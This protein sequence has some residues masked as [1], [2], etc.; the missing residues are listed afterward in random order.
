MVASDCLSLFF[1]FRFLFLVLGPKVDLTRVWGGDA[2][3]SKDGACDFPV[4]TRS[5]DIKRRSSDGESENGWTI[6]ECWNGLRAG[7][8]T[9]A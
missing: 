2:E 3:G 1:S 9:K 7:P 4:L 5:C 6:M 8:P